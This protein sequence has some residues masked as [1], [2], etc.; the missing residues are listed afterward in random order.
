MTTENASTSEIVHQPAT[1]AP[2]VPAE[3]IGYATKA[4]T[5]CRQIVR[6]LA[7]N[8]NGKRYL[9]I[10]AWQSLAASFGCACSSRDVERVEGGFRAIGEVRRCSDGAL[11]SQAEGFVGDDEN[12]WRGKPEFAK[13]AMCQSRSISRAARSA[14]AFAIALMDDESLAVTPYEEMSDSS[15]PPR[16][17]RNTANP[18]TKVL[19]EQGA[20][21]LRAR[22]DELGVAWADVLAR[23]RDHDEHAWS[24]MERVEL[25]SI[26]AEHLALLKAVLDSFE[27]DV[28]ATD[29]V[30]EIREDEIP[31]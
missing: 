2:L 26:Q 14:F 11:I 17:V 31:F 7:I 16:R 29:D 25:A 8:I 19:G 6:R 23:V 12:A 5:A 28:S 4:A 9:P 1:Q 30:G 15:P 20:A 18:P 13:R 21:R 24:A 22:L 10:E 3:Q 27:R